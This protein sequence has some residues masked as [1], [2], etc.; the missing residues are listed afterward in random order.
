M[1]SSYL[2]NKKG[3]SEMVAYALL[4]AIALSLSLLVYAWLKSYTP[5][6]TPTCPDDVSLIVSDFS[7]D[8]LNLKLN[9]TLDNKGLFTVDG[10][11]IKAS[12]VTLNNRPGVAI[13]KFKNE[14]EKNDD[15]VFRDGKE[16]TGGLKAGKKF[17]RVYSYRHNNKITGIEVEPFIVDEKGGEVIC[18]KST[19]SEPVNCQGST[20]ITGNV[21]SSSQLNS[22]SGATQNL[23][24]NDQVTFDINSQQHSLQVNGITTSSATIT[25]A[26]TPQTVTLNVGE[27]KKFELTGDNWYDLQ[28]TLDGITNNQVTMTLKSIQELIPGQNQTATVQTNQTSSN[29]TVTNSTQPVNQT[30]PGNTTNATP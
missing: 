6:Q 22:A 16:Y 1:A 8:A 17:N 11:F 10:F 25:L 24:Q 23:N 30:A 18:S 21:I 3:L 19:V 15:S 28:T 5:G 9:L 29:Q 13:L 14:S 20:G 12:N 7:C 2:L 27:T 26:S 4:I